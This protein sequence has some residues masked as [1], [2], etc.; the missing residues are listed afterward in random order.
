VVKHVVGDLGVSIDTRMAEKRV[1]CLTKAVHALNCSHPGVLIPGTFEGLARPLLIAL[2]IGLCG[3]CAHFEHGVSDEH[4]KTCPGEAAPR[5]TTPTVVNLAR[6]EL[7]RAGYRLDDY[8]TPVVYYN[9]LP[10]SNGT[11]TLFFHHRVP[12]PDNFIKIWVDDRT[13]TARLAPLPP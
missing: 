3:G 10:I 11:W 2:V 4:P 8:E 1:R 5:L 13:G 7:E 9:L 12:S 6:A